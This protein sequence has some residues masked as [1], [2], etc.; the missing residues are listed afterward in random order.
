MFEN[1]FLVK[2]IIEIFLKLQ[3]KSMQGDFFKNLT[4]TDI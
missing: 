1:L 4:S 2:F 3:I